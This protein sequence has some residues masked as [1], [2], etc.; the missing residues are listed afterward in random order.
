[1]AVVAGLAALVLVVLWLSANR[2]PE[3]RAPNPGEI[4]AAVASRN[5]CPPDRVTTKPPVESGAPAWTITVH[6]PRS[7]DV[8]RF[9]LDLEA[10]V[11]NAGGRIEPR[12]LTERG[13]YGLARL[14]GD[15]GGEALQVLVLGEPPPEPR[16]ARREKKARGGR[17]AVVLDDAGYS[18]DSVVQISRLPREVAVAVLP[19]AP[20]TR[21]VARALGAQGRELLV[22]MP[23]E[24]LAGHGPGP[25]EGAVL[26]GLEPAEIERRVRHAFDVVP[27]AVGLNNHMGSRATAD[28]DTMKAVMSALKPQGAY[29]LD[30]RTTAESIAERFARAAGVPALRR[31]VFLDV[32]DEPTAVRGALREALA[33]ARSEGRAVAIGHVQPVTLEVLAQELHADLGGVRLVA[34]SRLLRP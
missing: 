34:P 32:A 27:G 14:E 24:P 17:L 8:S 13:G 23:M 20:H 22:H 4:V 15:V 1:M 33:I 11:H 21:E 6:A 16:P 12:S 28:G 2:E 7:F 19:N 18:L 25:G 3:I 26:V 30:S 5:G 31:N 10:E 9:Q 29:F